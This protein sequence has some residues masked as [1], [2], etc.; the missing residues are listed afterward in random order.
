MSYPFHIVHSAAYALND[1]STVGAVMYLYRNR[2]VRGSITGDWFGPVGLS[3]AGQVTGCNHCV[4]T[5]QE[6]F[7]L[8]LLLLNTYNNI[9]YCCICIFQGLHQSIILLLSPPILLHLRILG[10]AICPRYWLGRHGLWS[11]DWTVSII[12]SPLPATTRNWRVEW[13]GSVHV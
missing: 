11:E 1:L 7:T 2:T 6:T 13:N 9:F 5:D 8:L 3:P 4:I 12:L 10:V